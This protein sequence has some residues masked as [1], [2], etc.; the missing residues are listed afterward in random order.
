[1]DAENKVVG[2]GNDPAEALPHDTASL[3]GDTLAV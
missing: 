1:V 2:T 3:R